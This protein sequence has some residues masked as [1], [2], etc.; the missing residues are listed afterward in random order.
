[1]GRA[2][3]EE[4]CESYIKGLL[5][6]EMDQIEAPNFQSCHSFASHLLD[7]W[8][9]FFF[10]FKSVNKL[11][12]VVFTLKVFLLQAA[13]L[14][15]LLLNEANDA[16]QRQAGPPLALHHPPPING[17]PGTKTTEVGERVSELI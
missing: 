12:N 5:V 1:M 9:D 2:E 8:G 3:G 14:E 15:Q 11:I 16:P 6:L 17:Q 10:F 7:L 13:L 4:K